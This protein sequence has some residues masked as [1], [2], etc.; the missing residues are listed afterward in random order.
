MQRMAETALL[1]KVTETI[2]SRYRK[3]MGEKDSL[4]AALRFIYD[5]KETWKR[6]NALWY[7]IVKLKVAVEDIAAA[8]PKHGGIEKLSRLAAKSRQNGEGDA[9]RDDDIE[10]DDDKEKPKEYDKTK[11]KFGRLISVGLSPRL[12]AKLSQFADKTRIKI[13]GYVRM[14]PDETPTIEAKRV[15]KVVSKEAGTKKAATKKAVTKKN[16]GNSKHKSGAKKTDYGDEGDDA[17]D[18]D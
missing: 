1:V 11:H 15:A 4:Y 3:K 12:A 17:G 5:T 8:I 7:L 16:G 9:D 18:W 2:E 6:A 13:I 10:D 14:V